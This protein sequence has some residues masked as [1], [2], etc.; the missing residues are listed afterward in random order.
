MAEVATGVLHS[1][2]NVLNS[3][4][5]SVTLVMAGLRG[6]RAGNVQ[7]VA[8]LMNEHADRLAQFLQSDERGREIPGYLAQLGEHLDSESRVLRT[9]MQA[10]VT[11]VEHIG[12]IVASQQSHARRGGISEEVDLAELLD[13]AIAL[14]FAGSPDLTIRRNYQLAPRL[15][16]DRH[17]LMQIVGNLLSNARHALKQ[18][19]EARVLTVCIRGAAPDAVA[20]DVQDSGVGMD[21]QV[22]AR[23]FE[24]GFTTKSDG[25]GFGLHASGNLAKELDGQL[26]GHSEGPGRGSRFTL[27]L[28]MSCAA[29]P[30][31]RLA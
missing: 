22:L 9:E 11:H 15:V 7:R 29:E 1:V 24:F 17:K 5:V 20:I 23:L 19:R 10:I 30:A 25:H 12:K 27:R 31:R 8:K 18:Q 2:G 13:S 16:L 26:S 14:H 3:L 21:E 4:G 28:P 6:S